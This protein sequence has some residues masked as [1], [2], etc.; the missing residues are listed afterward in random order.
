MAHRRKLPAWTLL[1]G[2]GDALHARNLFRFAAAFCVVAW[3]HESHAE[4]PKPTLAGTWSATA[5]TE[6]WS[7]KEWGDACGPKPTSGGGAPAGTVTV[8]DQGSELSFSGAGRAFSTASCWEPTPGLKRS[9]HAGGKRGWSSTCV[10]PPGDPRRA[11]VNTRMSATDDTIVFNETGLFEFN[12][13]DTT[14][15]ASVARSRSFKLKQRAGEAEPAV[16]AP[17]A[18]ATAAPPPTST[19]TV[20]SAKPP[21]PDCDPSAPPARL[22]VRPARKLL[23]PGEQLD[24]DIRVLDARTCIVQ[25]TPEI[26]IEEASEGLAP[27]VKIEKHAVHIDDSAPEGTAF[28]VVT[29]GGKSVRTSIEVTPAD[30]YA[31]LLA[32]RG[33]D[34]R[35]ED[36]SALV[37][38]IE[39]GLGGPEGTAEDT[40]RARRI[41]FLA[42]VGGVAGALGI[43]A[44]ALVRRGR[45]APPERATEAPPPPN[46]AFFETTTPS[47]MECPKCL[48]VF[49]PEAGFCPADGTALVPSKKAPPPPPAPSEPPPAGAAAEPKKKKREVGKICPTC[50]DTFAA[51]ASFCGKDGTQLVQI[52]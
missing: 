28:V 40:A 50:G 16:S 24:L 51:D 30:R 31:E 8:A 14:C 25:A 34:E 45:R 5:M 10:S 11:T 41:T 33:L 4:E 6:A 21:P 19:P 42:I 29:M 15:K 27:H 7:T 43:L 39:T 32:K 37:A 44:L 38:E 18:T 9:S 17:T 13:Q 1:D 49:A 20:E 12:I 3:S 2:L 52:N 36:T 26:K 22:E 46:V 48:R 47:A 23:R 35:G